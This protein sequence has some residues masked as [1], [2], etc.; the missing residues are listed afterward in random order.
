VP[1][2]YFFKTGIDMDDILSSNP[3]A[4]RML[5]VFWKLSFIKFDDE[6]NQAFRDILLK[7]NQD[8]LLDAVEGENVFEFRPDR[9]RLAGQLLT[10]QYQFGYGVSSILSN[11]A[12]GRYLMH[13][14]ALELG[15]LHQLSVQDPQTCAVLGVWDYLSHQVVASPFKPVDYMDKMDLFGY[16]YIA[17]FRPT[18][19]SFLVGE[20][21][22]DAA[23]HE[24]IDQ[25]LKYIDWVRDE[26]CFGD[27]SMIQACLIAFDF[28]DS[29]IQHKQR[30]GTRKYTVGVRPAVSM[31]WNNITLVRYAFSPASGQVQLISV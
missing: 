14:M 1:D 3:P 8:A 18:K 5:R 17:G 31:E 12:N 28:D 15:I 7:R 24:N 4:F 29:V 27:Y 11:C 19:A 20:V 10:D 23:T 21:K 26:Y 6:E 13:E 22:K 2:P 25:L 9:T 16:T 30:F